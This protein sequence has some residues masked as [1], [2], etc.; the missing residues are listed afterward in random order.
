MKCRSISGC[1]KSISNWDLSAYQKFMNTK[2]ITKRSIPL[3]RIPFDVSRVLSIKK[4]D[5]RIRE[6]NVLSHLPWYRHIFVC[7]KFSTDT[8]SGSGCMVNGDS[9]CKNHKMISEHLNALF[10]NHFAKRRIFRSH[11]HL[12]TRTRKHNTIKKSPRLRQKDES[13]SHFSCIQV[14][15]SSS[16]AQIR[17]NGKLSS[18]WSLLN[19]AQ[20]YILFR[21]FITLICIFDVHLKF[22][23]WN[24]E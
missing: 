23:I 2:K 8:E 22:E 21:V 7:Y 11:T 4:Y 6:R 14:N 18:S 9:L 13:V 20:V 5:F 10:T 16:V 1:L 24:L 17:T 15:F 12:H 19:W 3:I